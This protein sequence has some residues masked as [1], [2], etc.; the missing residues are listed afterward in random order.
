MANETN[1]PQPDPEWDARLRHW[2]RKLGRLRLGVEPLD[3][4]LTRYRRVTLVLTLVPGVIAS[5][6]VAIF[7]AFRRPDI[8]LIVTA[9][10][11]LPVVALAWIDYAVLR[12]RASG[13]L[14]DLRDHEARLARI[15]TPG[16]A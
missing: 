12:H 11:F 9:V 16:N 7:T 2:R 1:P 15:K 13:Y 4:Q 5:I 10:L 14:R 8:G 3:E 6:I